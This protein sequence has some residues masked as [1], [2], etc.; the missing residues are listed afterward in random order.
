M[1]LPRCPACPDG[2]YCG[3]GCTAF[4]LDPVAGEEEL[5]AELLAEPPSVP[6]EL[7]AILDNQCV[8]CGR[9]P[10][11]PRSQVCASCARVHP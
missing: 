9:A 11:Q 4:E 3:Y 1:I 8:A 6:P 10:R 2:E 7:A 5:L